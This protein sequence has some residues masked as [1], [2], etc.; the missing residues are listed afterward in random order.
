M[1]SNKNPLCKG[2]KTV[3][4]DEGFLWLMKFTPLVLG[5]GPQPWM[6]HILLLTLTLNRFHDL[7]GIFY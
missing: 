6:F 1:D 2:L 3:L 4:S 7:G 5:C